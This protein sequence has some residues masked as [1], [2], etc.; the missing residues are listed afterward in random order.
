MSSIV[1][2]CITTGAVETITSAS[3][4][5]RVPRRRL[6]HVDRLDLGEL[7]LRRLVELAPAELGE[8]P[9]PPHARRGR[10]EQRV[11][12]EQPADRR[13]RRPVELADEQRVCAELPA[14][15]LERPEQ[16]R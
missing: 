3:S 7:R 16:E 11:R 9:G 10:C 4:A 1:M 13:L 5:G 15:L 14:E 6:A 8:V 12:S 2:S